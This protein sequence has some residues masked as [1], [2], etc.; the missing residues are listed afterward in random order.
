MHYFLLKTVLCGQTDL[1]FFSICQSPRWLKRAGMI[2]NYDLHAVASLVILLKRDCGLCINMFSVSKKEI[3]K[4]LKSN[5]KL[6]TFFKCSSLNS[7]P[8]LKKQIVV[9]MN[10]VLRLF[11]SSLKRSTNRGRKRFRDLILTSL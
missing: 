2:C 9:G 11:M 10:N 5:I 1:K 7:T 4:K 6:H 8:L 3:T